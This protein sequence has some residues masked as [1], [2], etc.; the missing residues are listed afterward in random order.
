LKSTRT[1]LVILL[2]FLSISI[3]QNASAQSVARTDVYH[4]HFTHAAL[5]KAAPLAD[6]LKTEDPKS[7]MPSHR[8][9]LRH[10]D[11]DDWDY[12]V[13]EHLG[14]KA[15]IE[16]AGNPMPP[17]ARD[18]SSWHGDTFVNGPSWPEFVRALGLG[19]NAAKTAGSVYVVSVYRAAPG[20][21][22][23]LEKDLSAAPAANDPIA[24][25][26]LLQHLEGAPWTFLAV[27]RYNSW[28]DYATSETMSV[29]ET[30]KGTGGWFT[31]REHMS[32][33]ADTLTD[34]IAP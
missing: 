16:A 23:E 20:H 24:G 17:A 7:P 3:A 29:S 33:H 22:D 27:T 9:V 1:F 19:D 12:V 31:L 28:H 8:I 4:V 13:I 14:T 34:R 5:G 11:G 15:T 6:Y 32:Y 18:L 25:A 2:L 10:Q 21:R 26:V 30:N